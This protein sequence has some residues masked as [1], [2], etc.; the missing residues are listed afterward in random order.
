MQVAGADDVDEGALRGVDAD[1]GAPACVQRFPSELERAAVELVQAAW[2]P[3]DR[4]CVA[5]R[6][7]DVDG[8]RDGVDQPVAGQGALKAE[9]GAGDAFGDL[10]QVYVSGWRVGPAVD[11]PPTD[12]TAPVSR[13][14]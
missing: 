9:R 3:Q 10:D 14:R 8:G 6:D 2:R 13:R 1:R 11:A 7:R 12:I 5:A 4:A